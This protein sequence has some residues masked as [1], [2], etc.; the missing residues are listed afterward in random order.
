MIFEWCQRHFP[1]SLASI[2]C[3]AVY[4]SLIVAVWIRWEAPSAA[5][6]YAGF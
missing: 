1:G 2:I 3:G 5:F 6:R 4:A